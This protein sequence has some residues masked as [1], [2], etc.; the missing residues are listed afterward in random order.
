[1]A[2]LILRDVDPEQLRRDIAADV[3][4]ELKAVLADQFEPRLLERP[5]MAE[6]IGIGVSTLDQLV[7]AGK[8]PS[9]QVNRRRLFDPA[10][11]IE[12]LKSGPDAD[13]AISGGALHCS[14][15]KQ[16][17]HDT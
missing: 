14:T 9:V 12:A 1:M 13:G 15:T 10:A 2:D 7:T 5:E 17:D 4:R 3:V 16:Q 8:I 11:V 6:R